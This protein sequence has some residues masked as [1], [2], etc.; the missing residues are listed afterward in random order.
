[1]S[2][3]LKLEECKAQFIY[4]QPFVLRRQNTLKTN[5]SEASEESTV[6]P[7]R[8]FQDFSQYLT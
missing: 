3:L 8:L 2:P 1:M 5:P 4:F 7:P 6:P